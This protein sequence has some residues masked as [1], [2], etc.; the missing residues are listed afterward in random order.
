MY[1]E[2]VLQGTCLCT[3]L[4]LVSYKKLTAGVCFVA[5]CVRPLSKTRSRNARHASVPFQHTSVIAAKQSTAKLALMKQ[6]LYKSGNT[7]P[8]PLSVK[9]ARN[10]HDPHIVIPVFSYLLL[11]AAFLLSSS[12][13]F[14]RSETSF[15]FSMYVVTQP[16][17]ASRTAADPES[18]RHGIT[19][20][21]T[22]AHTC[23]AAV[24]SP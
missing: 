22:L 11:T 7:S 2:P 24:A 14:I 21:N 1:Y 10:R 8:S 3:P 18:M 13:T 6:K 23:R 20:G 15:S 9:K 17:A 4:L 12:S 16:N 5:F 19:D